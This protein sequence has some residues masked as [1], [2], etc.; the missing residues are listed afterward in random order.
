MPKF[1]YASFCV[2]LTV[3]SDLNLVKM[4]W[5][6]LAGE[7]IEAKEVEVPRASVLKLVSENCGMS[8]QITLIERI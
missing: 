8:S 7:R 1:L 5:R 6:P 2:I 4:A 3:T